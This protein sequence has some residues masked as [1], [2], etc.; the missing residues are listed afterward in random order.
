LSLLAAGAGIDLG[1]GPLYRG[2]AVSALL[3]DAALAARHG[4]TCPLK[5]THTTTRVP[6]HTTHDYLSSHQITPCSSCRTDSLCR[7]N[8]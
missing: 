3:D 5:Q 4:K 7:F 6:N 1:A 8:R 2:A